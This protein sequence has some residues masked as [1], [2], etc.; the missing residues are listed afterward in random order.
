MWGKE[1]QIASLILPR[2]S[3][4]AAV[5]VDPSNNQTDAVIAGGTDEKNL[6][7]DS[8]R[9]VV[10]ASSV[11]FSAGI[12]PPAC[13]PCGGVCPEKAAVCCRWHVMGNK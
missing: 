13:R 4:C 6:L 1:S 2:S 3:F 9:V 5:A 12:T 10:G 8:Y 7:G 11:P